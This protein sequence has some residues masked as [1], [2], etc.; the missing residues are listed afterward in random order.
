M[1]DNLNPEQRRR[2]MARI[3]SSNTKPEVKVRK[4][5]HALGYRFRLH[6]KNLP[7]KPDLV[8][9]SLGKAIFVHGCF[10]HSHD[11]RYGRVEPQ[12]NVEYWKK[13]RAATIERDR[14]HRKALSALGW[15]SLV[16]W[17]CQLR[18]MSQ[19]AKRL[20]GFLG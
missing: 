19:I 16:I 5:A 4:A 17:E 10:W 20:T 6:R 18:S 15:S 2:C 7:G 12:T 1:V 13:K 14:R 9:P 8:F 11:C 3:R